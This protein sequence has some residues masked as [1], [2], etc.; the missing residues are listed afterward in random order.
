MTDNNFEKAF[1]HRIQ[2]LRKQKN[3]RQDHFADLVNVSKDT[4]SNIERAKTIPRLDTVLRIAENLDVEVYELFQMHDIPTND[5]EKL[6]ILNEIVKL[7]S[8]QPDDIL[9]FSLKQTKELI[10][11]K[12]SLADKVLK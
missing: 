7:L 4:M 3:I 8:D 1:A 6:K 12:Q 2:T 9:K 11:L 10:K 5:K